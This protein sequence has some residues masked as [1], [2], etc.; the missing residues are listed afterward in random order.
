MTCP[1]QSCSRKGK[2]VSAEI[3]LKETKYP[4]V[5]FASGGKIDKMANCLAGHGWAS[6]EKDKC[7]Q[8]T[9]S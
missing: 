9:G 3:L 5:D 4:L 8:S 2:I 1:L 6:L 7:R